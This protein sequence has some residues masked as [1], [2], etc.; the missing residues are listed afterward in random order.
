M[1][2]EEALKLADQIRVGS[3]ISELNVEKSPKNTRC[4]RDGLN[5]ISNDKD[6]AI[7]QVSDDP[8]SSWEPNSN[9]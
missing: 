3:L 8:K 9:L 7:N 6:N 1:E 5:C 4:L 2:S